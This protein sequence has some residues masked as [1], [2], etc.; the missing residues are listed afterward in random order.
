MRQLL[1]LFCIGLKQVGDFKHQVQRTAIADP[2]L[3]MGA[4]NSE[5]EENPTQKQ[6]NLGLFDLIYLFKER[7]FNVITIFVDKVNNSFGI[8]SQILLKLAA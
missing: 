2:H 5:N 3:L 4:Q 7:F 1:C 6:S 8:D